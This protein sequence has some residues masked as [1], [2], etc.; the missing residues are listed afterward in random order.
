L[1]C[2]VGDWRTTLLEYNGGWS[3]G[4]REPACREE[5]VDEWVQLEEVVCP[6]LFR[7]ESEA[8]L[9]SGEEIRRERRES[10]LWWRM[11]SE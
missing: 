8:R 9:D 11:S 10:M 5:D 2:K 6:E 3:G 4:P 1:K 7:D